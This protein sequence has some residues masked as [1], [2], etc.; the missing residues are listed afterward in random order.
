MPEES[1]EPTRKEILEIGIDE[2]GIVEDQVVETYYCPILAITEDVDG[3]FLRVGG[4]NGGTNVE[5][6]VPFEALEENGW[7]SPEKAAGLH[8]LV[9]NVPA[10]H[11][12]L[13]RVLETC[14]L[15]EDDTLQ[16]DI[17]RLLA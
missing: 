11:G 13:H 12:M 8:R 3:R 1:V 7:A 6:R 17:E 15:S 5:I 4:D 10:L 14:H 16:G 2:D 9:R